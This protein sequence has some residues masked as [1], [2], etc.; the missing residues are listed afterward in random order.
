MALIAASTG[1]A[2]FRPVPQGAHIGRCYRVID[3]GTQ[4][5]EFQGKVRT[6][7]KVMISW[8]LFGE[9]ED[10][11]PLV[12]DDGRPL[13][14][15]KRYTL[16]LSEKATLRADLESWRG[17]AFTDDELAGFD[18]K[19]LLGIY[20][21]VNVTHTSRDGKTYANVAG[22]TPLPKI[23]RDNKPIPVNKSQFFDVTEPD[24]AL[25]ETF[26]ERL[27]ETIN[28]CAEWN[29]QAANTAARK[30]PGDGSAGVGGMDD[31]I[32]F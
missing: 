3:L 6:A 2:D 28:A 17:R 25:F 9:D 7:R 10:G 18:L 12:M 26:S 31:D 11:G 13:S 8:E 5:S 22:L 21:L 30:S 19:N 27:K 16:S 15:S 24:M 1:G 29:P 23:M 20:G 32:P 4:K 14:I